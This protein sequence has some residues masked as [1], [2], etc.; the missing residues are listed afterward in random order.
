MRPMYLG[1][2]MLSLMTGGAHAAD[3]AVC[4]FLPTSEMPK[5]V[6]QDIRDDDF[7]YAVGGASG[8]SGSSYVPINTFINNAREDA[9]ANLSNSIRSSIKVST[10][11]TIESKKSN[12]S[13][14]EVRKE[15]KQKTEVVSQV[16]LAAVI[17]DAKWLDTK[18]CLLWY[19]VKVSK[20]GAEFAVKAYV[21]EV[22]ERLHKKIEQLTHREIEQILSDNGFSPKLEHAVQALLNNSQAYYRGQ[23]YNVAELYQQSGFDW[24]NESDNSFFM[25]SIW[26]SNSPI[27]H[28][29]YLYYQNNAVTS[30]VRSNSS[31]NQQIHA[32]TQLKSFGVDLNKVRVGAGQYFPHGGTD[33]YSSKKTNSL[34]SERDGDI[35]RES[36]EA[37]LGGTLKTPLIFNF[38]SNS[39][40]ESLGLLHF[41]V[42]S[43]RADLIQPLLSL[44]VDINQTTSLGYTSLAL[45]IEYGQLGFAKQLLTLGANP[46]E[47]DSIAYKI[48]YLLQHLN[49]PDLYNPQFGVP[50]AM[51]LPLLQDV[52]S[53][54]DLNAR[55]VNKVKKMILKK[56]PINLTITTVKMK[57]DL[58]NYDRKNVEKQVFING[59]EIK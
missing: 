53:E 41:A 16:A 55:E 36:R 45:A 14:A 3:D 27:T 26:G 8:K 30:V 58:Y 40:K 6:N 9:V 13:K 46:N 35:Y 17:D 52:M 15:V 19:R 12:K 24:V 2:A 28:F 23:V 39:K 18:Q 25:R 57:E 5:W 38:K 21:D 11:R 49:T 44:G 51:N 59:E 32:L 56:Y 34:F 31:L 48:A 7:Y 50:S 42:I 54:M 29:S 33:T 22:S 37:T 10:K 1:A 4:Q 47:Q 43:H 20:A